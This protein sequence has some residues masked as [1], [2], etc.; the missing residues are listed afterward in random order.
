MVQRE[1]ALYTYRLTSPRPFSR[2]GGR[3]GG[4][5]NAASTHTS[6][7]MAFLE[8]PLDVNRDTRYI[9]PSF[10]ALCVLCRRRRVSYRVQLYTCA[11]MFDMLILTETVIGPI[12]YCSTFVFV[13]LY[14]Y[15]RICINTFQADLLALQQK[16]GKVSAWAA[17]AA[18]ACH[19]RRSMEIV[20]GG[21][22]RD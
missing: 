22:I 19:I 16:Q 6:I 18:A 20:K 14:I 13:Q 9:F 10:T 17:N 15:Q 2:V 7:Y 1:R 3:R 5:T 8:T 12:T 4:P 11:A 21:H